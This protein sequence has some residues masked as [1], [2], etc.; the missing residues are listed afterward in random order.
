ML[1]FIISLATG[2]FGWLAGV[3]PVSP[4]SGLSVALSGFGNAL[5]W[6]NWLVPVGQMAT[7]YGAWLAGCAI[8]QIVSYVMK[9]MDTF[10]GMFGSFAGK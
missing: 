3:L 2:L 7:L 6:L 5:G 8:W 1:S 9:R 4:F 10:S